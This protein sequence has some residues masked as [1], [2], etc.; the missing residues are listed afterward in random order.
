MPLTAPTNCW[1][2]TERNYAEAVANSV[3][4][5]AMV[6][7]STAAQARAFIYHDELDHPL[8][9]SAYTPD[10]LAERRHYAMVY[11]EG[12]GKRR[13]ASSRFEPRGECT[14]YLARLVPSLSLNS[15]IPTELWRQ[16]KNII[17]D[18]VQQ[19]VDY[20]EAHI[21]GGPYTMAYDVT[22]GPGFNHRD[23]WASQGAWQGVE[24]TLT[25]GVES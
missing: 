5:Q 19:T 13:Q 3:A 18:I 6:G 17:G 25:W 12:Y 23:K 2:A 21:N 7:A 9:G 14:L 22:D 10:E 16:W 24:F 11:C 20:A 8:D 15:D 1:T 4:F